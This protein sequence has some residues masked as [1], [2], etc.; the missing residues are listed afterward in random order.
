MCSNIF[1]HFLLIYL[2]NPHYF[3]HMSILI[4][5][6]ILFT[7]LQLILLLHL[8][9]YNFQHIERTL[10]CVLQASTLCSLN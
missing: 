2:T 3:N 9:H 10:D 1:I 8:L 6:L 5:Q 7:S 4:F